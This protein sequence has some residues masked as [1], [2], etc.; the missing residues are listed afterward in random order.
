MLFAFI[1]TKQNYNCY[2][3]YLDAS[4]MEENK[5]AT[6]CC[7]HLFNNLMLYQELF[8]AYC[9]FSHEPESEDISL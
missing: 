4:D 3:R 6:V 2:S 1:Q 9:K 5:L 7:Y 8:D